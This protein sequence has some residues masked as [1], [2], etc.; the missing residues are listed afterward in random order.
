MPR[1]PA[2]SPQCPWQLSER[3]LCHPLLLGPLRLALYSPH[4]PSTTSGRRAF[5]AGEAINTLKILGE[6]ARDSGGW[7]ESRRCCWCVCCMLCFRLILFCMP[8]ELRTLRPLSED[9]V[10]SRVPMPPAVRWIVVVVLQESSPA[11]G[12]SVL[13]VSRQPSRIPRCRPRPRA[14]LQRDVRE[15]AHVARLIRCWCLG[16]DEVEEG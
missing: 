10:L 15:Y 12:A 3:D 9:R 5:G 1:W 7:S 16:E 2:R 14:A 11:G 4:P 8:R 13:V 6:S